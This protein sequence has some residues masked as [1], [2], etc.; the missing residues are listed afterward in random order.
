M[1]IYFEMLNTTFKTVLRKCE[2][3]LKKTMNKYRRQEQETITSY[4]VIFVTRT[5]KLLSVL[6]PPCTYQTP[7]MKKQKKPLI[8]SLYYT[9][10]SPLF[11]H[12][13]C[14]NIL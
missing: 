5:I 9:S 4:S 7:G 6:N 12:N 10:L 13:I 2:N 1:F 11:S 3:S 14:Y 8:S